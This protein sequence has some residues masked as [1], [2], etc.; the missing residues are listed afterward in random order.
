MPPSDLI[1]QFH[2]A[3]IG[4]SHRVATIPQ[5]QLLTR[6]LLQHRFV[7]IFNAVHLIAENVCGSERGC[8]IL[9]LTFVL[10]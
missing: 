1:I 9:V 3:T 4:G 5:M 6:T 10:L 2:M 7:V 8:I